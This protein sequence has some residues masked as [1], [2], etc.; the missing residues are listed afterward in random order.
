MNGRN[1][2][3]RKSVY[4]TDEEWDMVISKME[5]VGTANFDGYARKM[6][7][8]GVVIRTDFSELRKVTSELGKIGSNVNQ[9]AKRANESRNVYKEDVEEILNQLHLLKQIVNREI[10]GVLEALKSR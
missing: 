9:I 8:D 4:Y 1:R 5:Q 6:T 7:I 3:L 10:G 2:K